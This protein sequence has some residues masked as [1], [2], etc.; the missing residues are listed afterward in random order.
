MTTERL[1][2]RVFLTLVVLGV[3]S[4]MTPFMLLLKLLEGLYVSVQITADSLAQAWSEP[5]KEQPRGD[6]D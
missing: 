6:Q 5:S 3:A 4:L 2:L 1:F